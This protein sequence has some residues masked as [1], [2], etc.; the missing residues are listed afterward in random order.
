M[1]YLSEA[2]NHTEAV[3]SMAMS[4]ADTLNSEEV[5]DSSLSIAEEND[6]IN[7]PNPWHRDYAANMCGLHAPCVRNR[8]YTFLISSSLAELRKMC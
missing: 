8:S 5:H 7:Q 6:S 2:L 1:H 3:R 4:I